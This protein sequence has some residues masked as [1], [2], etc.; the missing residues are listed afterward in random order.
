MWRQQMKTEELNK[1]NWNT[2]IKEK[3][4]I[5]NKPSKNENFRFGKLQKIQIDW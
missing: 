1:E 5:E 4:W 3:V 2:K